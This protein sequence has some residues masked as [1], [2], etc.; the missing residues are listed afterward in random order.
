MA[1]DDKQPRSRRTTRHSTSQSDA[2]RPPRRSPSRQRAS[3]SPAEPETD[4]APR[5]PV[6]GIGASAGGLEA[7]QEFFSAMPADSGVAFVVVTHMH[8]EHRSLLPELLARCTDMP[9]QEISEGM[10]VMPN[11]VYVTAPG[12]QLSI[13]QGMLQPMSDNE[14][15]QPAIDYFLRTLARDKQERAIGIV[16]SGAGSD[17]TLGLQ[18]IKGYGGLTLTQDER[19]AKF[20]G[21]PHH[22]R[23]AGLVDHV[24]PAAQM[25]REIIAFVRSE[26]VQ[27]EDTQRSPITDELLRQIYLLLREHTKNDFSPYKTTTIRRRIERRMQVHQLD[28]PWEY[29]QFLRTHPQELDVLFRDLLITVTS[30]F[31]DS[32]AFEVLATRAVP[33][34][35]E[36]R[37]EHHTVRVWVLGC[38]TGEEAYSLAIVL[39]ECM[40]RLGTYFPVQI[41]ATE[42]DDQSIQVARAGTYPESIAHDVSPTRLERFFT[43]QDGCYVIRQDIREQVIFASHNM[44]SNPPFTKLDLLS[45]RNVLIYLNTDMQRRLIPMFHFTLLPK[46]LLFLGSSETIGSFTDLF[47]T[48]DS[49]WKIYRRLESAAAQARPTF[50][51]PPQAPGRQLSSRGSTPR[52][53]DKPATMHL[54][55]FVEH[56]LLQRFAPPSVLVNDKGDIIYIHGF[57]GMFLQPAPGL[58]GTQNVFAMAREG[59]R[60]ELVAAL[61]QAMTTEDVVQRRAEVKANGGL[62]SVEL[63]VHAVTQPEV[64]RGLYLITFH[65]IPTPVEEQQP[66][67]GGGDPSQ[68]HMQALEE[69]IQHLRQAL[70]N[71]MEE[72]ETVNEELKS[73]NEELQSTNEELQSSNE[74]LETSREEMQSLN[75]ELQT[76]NA[77]LQE[78]VHTLGQ[79]NDDMQN[80]LNSTNIATLFLDTELR[81]KRFTPQ[82]TQVFKLIASDL[83]R[84]IG[85]LVSYLAYDQLEDDA[86]GVLRTL[87]PKELE[88]ASRQGGWYSVRLTPY[89]T[90]EN[91]IDGVVV[92]FINITRLKE[93]EQRV[94]SLRL[95]ESIVQTV[96]EPLVVLDAKLHVVSANRAFYATFGVEPERVVQRLL[97]EIGDGAW[98]IPALRRLLEDVLP[99]NTVLDDFEVDDDF[100]H[101]GR[102]VLRLNARRLAG[103]DERNDLILLA[104]EDLTDRSGSGDAE[105]RAPDQ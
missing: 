39:Q 16:L 54:G 44:L 15:Q 43:H 45:C 29:L 103:G 91:I 11:Q 41:F 8:P 79:A 46:G 62:T 93:S 21:M 9:V 69:E 13:I 61:R 32:E 34:L 27:A 71:S 25:P 33:E 73:A 52:A 78:K 5:C 68:D 51:F 94:A 81:I 35:L 64:M 90:T 84:P 80:L 63:I 36:S 70:Q 1:A 24:L 83:G 82:A 14:P 23:A 2:R 49:H 48:L 10:P 67:R 75:E 55:A 72:S 22:A 56:L 60:L 53:S 26:Y 104:M 58:P 101:V 4:G 86:R 89:R 40:E 37:P 57:T 99:D 92:T 28:N 98:H 7:L 31:R 88:V 38:A 87:A 59:L 100:P 95:A 20:P 12:T 76:V 18:A 74:E 66:R 30:F 105:R 42:L 3:A 19:E 96:R 77:E 85:D 50:D 47:E 65:P 6:V 97:Y 102:K 17:G